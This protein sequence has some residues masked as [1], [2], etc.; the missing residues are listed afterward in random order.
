[1][2]NKPIGSSM[3]FT[4]G[5]EPCTPIVSVVKSTYHGAGP[6]DRAILIDTG[7]HGGIELS[8]ETLQTILRWVNER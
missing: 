7:E 4:G 1:M 5:A 6:G 2:V 8:E 3:C